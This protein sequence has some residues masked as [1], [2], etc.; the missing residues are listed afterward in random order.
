VLTQVA[1]LHEL[2]TSP[3]TNPAGFYT[4]SLKQPNTLVIGPYQGHLGCLRIAISRGV[5]GAAARE[6]KTQLVPDVT[7]F[8]GYIACS[9]G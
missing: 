4:V 1:P 5:C 8:P 9:S 3:C 6:M 7:A 2:S